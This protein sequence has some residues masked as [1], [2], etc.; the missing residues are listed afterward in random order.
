MKIL[1]ISVLASC[2]I[3]S[4]ET[5]TSNEGKEIEAEFVAAKNKVLS[6]RK[7]DKI[8]KIPFEKL[9]RESAGYA[10]YLQEHMMKWAQD[11]ASS[12]IIDELILLEVIRY[13]KKTT[14]GK[15]YLIEGYVKAL[16]KTS[17]LAKSTSTKVS[18]VFQ[19][20]TKATMDFSEVA[21]GTKR[22]IRIDKDSVLLLRGTMPYFVNKNVKYKNFITEK[23][24]LA[25]GK[26]AVVRAFIKNGRIQPNGVPS[27]SELTQARLVL[28]KQVGGASGLASAVKAE[29]I[30]GRIQY[31][32]TAINGNA[33]TASIQDDYGTGSA[34]VTFRYSE[35]QKKALRKE[36]EVLKA[37]VYAAG[38]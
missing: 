20:G 10:L 38:K 9:N 17:G 32:E 15:H 31:L 35:S 6:I 3:L 2:S 30:L 4:A 8:Y 25:V 12:P 18:V 23:T 14:E 24:L 16:G 22:K 7:G 13:S 5:W 27:S 28:A 21:D 26:K 29:K 19:G 34:T 33:G 11:N 37:Q 1:L 36:L